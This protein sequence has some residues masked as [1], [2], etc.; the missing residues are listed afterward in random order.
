M[1][2]LEFPPINEVIRW[3]DL[4][5]SFEKETGV[6]VDAKYDTEAKKTVG[7]AQAIA[8]GGGGG[9]WGGLVGVQSTVVVCPG[10]TLSAP[11]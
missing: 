8:A 1:L 10:A 11:A 3:Q 9:G 5:T 6:R 4:F 7:L 2:A